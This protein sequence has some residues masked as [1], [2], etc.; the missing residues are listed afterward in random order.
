MIDDPQMLAQILR[1][2]QPLQQPINPYAAGSA[3]PY[4]PSANIMPVSGVGRIKDPRYEVASRDYAI[5][6]KSLENQRLM[7]QRLAESGQEAPEMIRAG[8]ISVAGANPLSAFNQGLRGWLGMRNQQKVNEKDEILAGKKAE[9]AAA[10]GSIEQQI[11]QENRDKEAEKSQLSF[12]KFQEKKRHAKFL[13]DEATESSALAKT[14]EARAVAKELRDIAAAANA[15]LEPDTITTREMSNDE[16]DT[17]EAWT[18]GSGIWTSG[19]DGTP[20]RV[21]QNKWRRTPTAT[22][23]VTD[24]DAGTDL[25]LENIDN[26]R[27]LVIDNIGSAGERDRA[28]TMV[29]AGQ[30]FSDVMNMG[31]RLLSEGKEYP[32]LAEYADDFGEFIGGRPFGDTLGNTLKNMAYTEEQMAFIGNMANAMADLRKSR[33]GAN[34]TATEIQLFKDFDPSA[35]G[36]KMGQRIDRA[37]RMQN[38]VNNILKQKGV[39]GFGDPPPRWEAMTPI[40][41]GDP[42]EQEGSMGNLESKQPSMEELEAEEKALKAFLES[43]PGVMEESL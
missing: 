9:S 22:A 2:R 26:R 4:T 29:S 27:R 21:D 40:Q 39:E 28:N 42:Q 7:A 37:R 32:I 10:I 41:I 43:F 31:N 30:Q 38:F 8:N 13:E 24:V 5:E 33:T 20:V 16:G 11:A 18:T 25:D 6:E 12:D 35:P 36:L 14:K 15:E 17:I 23:T 19:E 3:S 1:S 34:V